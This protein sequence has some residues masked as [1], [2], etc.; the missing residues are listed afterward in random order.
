MS[1]LKITPGQYGDTNVSPALAD[2][3]NNFMDNTKNQEVMDWLKTNSPENYA[4]AEQANKS[5]AA[6]ADV[7]EKRGFMGPPGTRYA[8]LNKDYLSL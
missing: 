8:V 2:K 4:L 6:K 3:I 7:P 5:M 1:D